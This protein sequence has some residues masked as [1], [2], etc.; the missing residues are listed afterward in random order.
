MPTVH[1]MIFLIGFFVN[2][3]VL[4][5]QEFITF[6]LSLHSGQFYNTCFVNSPCFLWN[7]FHSPHYL[8]TRKKT[9]TFQSYLQR[10]S[11]RISLTVN[12]NVLFIWYIT[13]HT[14]LPKINCMEGYSLVSCSQKHS[15]LSFF[16]RSQGF[17]EIIR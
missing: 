17:Q 4:D 2:L 8:Q 10:P 9:A 7:N 14:A 5:C 12:Y 11:L 3:C 1:S 15:E 6:S 13:L 16:G